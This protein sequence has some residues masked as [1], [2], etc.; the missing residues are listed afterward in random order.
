MSGKRRRVI[1]PYVKPTSTPRER[2]KEKW[3]RRKHT[4]EKTLADYKA[5]NTPYF[6]DSAKWHG[7]Y[8][9]TAWQLHAAAR[10]RHGKAT[11]RHPR[12]NNM[13]TTA[14]VSAPTCPSPPSM[15]A[16]VC[17]CVNVCVYDCVRRGGRV[18]RRDGPRRITAV[19]LLAVR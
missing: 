3:M 9:D 15:E 13:A 8:T 7:H 12:G 14:Q 2:K 5:R 16:S 1:K 19:A 11:A 4:I 10:Q 18:R 6:G 17:V